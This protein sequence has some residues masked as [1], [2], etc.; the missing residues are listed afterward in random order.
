[1]IIQDENHKEPS[2]AIIIKKLNSKLQSQSTGITFEYKVIVNFRQG[3]ASHDK[4]G[5]N[6]TGDGFQCIS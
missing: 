1:M 2:R 5:S 4:R 3:G 6:C